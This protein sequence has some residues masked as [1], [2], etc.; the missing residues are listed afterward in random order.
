MSETLQRAAW[1]VGSNGNWFAD[2]GGWRY[3]VSLIDGRDNASGY[4][5]MRNGVSVAGPRGPYGQQ[6][7][8]TVDDAK[9]HAEWY[10]E[11]A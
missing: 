8:K 6:G 11:N 3:C 4:M 5:V 1:F 9:R 2:I 10:A 7:H